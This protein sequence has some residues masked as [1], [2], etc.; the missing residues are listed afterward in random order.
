VHFLAIA[1]EVIF[2]PGVALKFE[3]HEA[4]K[5]CKK[6]KPNKT[7]QNIKPKKKEKHL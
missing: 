1:G 2:T 5:F 4:S 6:A 7:K 3:K